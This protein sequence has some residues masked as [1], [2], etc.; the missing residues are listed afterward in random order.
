MTFE[1]HTVMYI[2]MH[3]AHAKTIV[4]LCRI[5]VRLHHITLQALKQ[6][7]HEMK[8][9]KKNFA[10]FR[11]LMGPVE[12]VHQRPDEGMMSTFVNFGDIPV[13]VKYFV[14]WLAT[15]VLQRNEVHYP[16]TKFLNDFLI[17]LP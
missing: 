8:L 10:R 15:K 16:L 9:Y 11:I 6:K 1:K 2:V 12:V 13:S 17:F 4:T 14:E 3:L 5:G 7:I